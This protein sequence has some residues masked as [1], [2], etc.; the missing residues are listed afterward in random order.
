MHYLNGFPKMSNDNAEKQSID[1]AIIDFL[2][3]KSMVDQTEKLVLGRITN[4]IG[5]SNQEVETS[6]NHLSSKNLIRKIYVQGKVGFE[7]TPK[8]KSSLE[9]LAKV[10]TARITKQLQEAIQQEQ[11][12][13]LR[14][15]SV[16]E[17]NQLKMNGKIIKFQIRT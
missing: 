4:K 2:S 13:K 9:E 1:D 15:N 6:I 3:K 8:G 16:K 17:L 7:L 10:E 14:M 11:K 12:A 5:S